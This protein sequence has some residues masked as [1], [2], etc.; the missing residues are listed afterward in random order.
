MNASN[1]TPASSGPDPFGANSRVTVLYTA[2]GTTVT[3]AFFESGGFRFRLT[4]LERFER[5]EHG[6][7]LQGRMYELWAW[8]EGQRVRL[9]Q[10]YDSQ[11]FGQ[12][13]RALT[14]AREH[15]GLV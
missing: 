11:E 6:G 8:F 12:V 3:T 2:D 15:A 7:W 13:C 10:C 14:R 4:E 1:A 5:V 9:F